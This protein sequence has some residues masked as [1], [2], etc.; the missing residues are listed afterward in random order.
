MLCSAVL[1]FF[2]HDIISDN[3]LKINNRAQFIP[4]N[5]SQKNV[6][7]E[8]S[9]DNFMTTIT[10]DGGTFRPRRVTI[11]SGNYLLVRNTSKTEL[12]W[13]ISDIPGVSTSRGYAEGE[14]FRSAISQIGTYTLKNKLNPQTSATIVVIH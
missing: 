5:A 11:Q 14:Q 2:S 9:A 10:F 7:G 8:S 13:L 3:L 1:G 6:L 12:M 4:T